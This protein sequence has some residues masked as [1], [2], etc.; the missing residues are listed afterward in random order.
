MW[1]YISPCHSCA[2]ESLLS[3]I[4]ICKYGIS[5]LIN[6]GINESIIKRITG[7]SSKIIDD[8]VYLGDVAEYSKIVNKKIVNIDDYFIY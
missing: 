4:S 8:C 7:T 6:V 5:Q 1:N 3:T 2:L